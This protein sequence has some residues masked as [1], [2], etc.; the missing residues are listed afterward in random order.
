MSDWYIPHIG[1]PLRIQPTNTCMS[2]ELLRIK[3]EDLPKYKP[4]Q[5]YGEMSNTNVC[6]SYIVAVLDIF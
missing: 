1:P 5:P 2:E 4:F 3:T 6:D